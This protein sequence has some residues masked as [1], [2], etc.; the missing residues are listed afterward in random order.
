MVRFSTRRSPRAV[1]E[2]QRVPLK[3]PEMNND[4]SFH[5]TASS[6]HNVIFE[7]SRGDAR[8]TLVYERSGME[9]VQNVKAGK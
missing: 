4:E 1:C 9:V 3:K 2:R 8:S 7:T 5:N 6:P